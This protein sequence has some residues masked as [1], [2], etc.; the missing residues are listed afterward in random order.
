MDHLNQLNSHLSFFL[1][2][3]LI[4]FNVRQLFNYNF[5]V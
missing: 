2:L 4:K 5:T 1:S 3:I